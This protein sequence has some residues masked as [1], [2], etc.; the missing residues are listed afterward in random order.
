MAVSIS[1]EHVKRYLEE[2]L[3][4]DKEVFAQL[5]TCFAEDINEF[6]AAEGNLQLIYRSA[7]KLK[8]TCEVYGALQLSWQMAELESAA[9]EKQV[10]N[11]L[12]LYKQILPDLI[13][14]LTQL[15]SLK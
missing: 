10:E 5:L 1:K 3:F 14:A 12:A 7:H 4:G 15:Q 9:K 8:P 6:K 2:E 13:S 11:A